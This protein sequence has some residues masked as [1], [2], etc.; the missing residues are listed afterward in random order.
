MMNDIHDS[1][2]KT[3][4]VMYFKWDSVIYLSC[5]VIHYIMCCNILEHTFFADIDT[6]CGNSD[7]KRKKI[8]PIKVIY[9]NQL[10][11]LC[12]SVHMLAVDLLM[13]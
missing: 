9:L 10:H 4:V 6:S 12:L 2:K 5:F 3:V 11:D 7:L 13:S 1:S 8:C